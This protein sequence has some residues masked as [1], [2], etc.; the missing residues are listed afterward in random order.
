MQSDEIQPYMYSYCRLFI[1]LIQY[2]PSYLILVWEWQVSYFI[3]QII[4]KK[5]F[6]GDNPVMIAAKLR[7]KDLVSDVLRSPRYTFYYFNVPFPRRKPFRG[8]MQFKA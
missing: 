6:L 1:P 7:H 8:Y 5:N 3:D 2:H 4:L